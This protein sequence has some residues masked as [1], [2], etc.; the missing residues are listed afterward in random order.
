MSE[1]K[2]FFTELNRIEQRII[3]ANEPMSS[4]LIFKIIDTRTHATFYG[5]SYNDDDSIV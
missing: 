3:R 1:E 2:N 4:Q 5:K